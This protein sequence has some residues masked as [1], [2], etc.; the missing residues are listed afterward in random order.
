MSIRLC[1]LIVSVSGDGASIVTSLVRG[2][3]S[4]V[5]SRA[6]DSLSSK[7]DSRS[8]TFIR[9]NTGGGCSGVV[10]GNGGVL[11]AVDG[12]GGVLVAIT[13]GD[14]GVLVAVAGDGGILLVS[15]DCGVLI[16]AVVIFSLS[17]VTSR[18]WTTGD[19]SMSRY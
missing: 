7:L 16:D 17:E 18:S 3:S 15:G 10:G 11:V 19:C 6:V 13:A 1:S 9:L 4:D 12:D 8:L 5:S 2:D 14:D